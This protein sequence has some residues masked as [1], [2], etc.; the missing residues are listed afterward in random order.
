MA[1]YEIAGIRFQTDLTDPYTKQYIEDYRVAAD[2]AP[3][4]LNITDADVEFER[5]I[6]P[7]APVGMLV[8]IAL[9]RKL[10]KRLL[11]RYQG[12]FLHG[13]ALLYKGKAYMFVAPSGTGKTTHILL[14]KKC[15]GDQVAILNGDKPFMRLENGGITVYSGPWRGKEGFGMKASAP[16]GGVIL[17]HRGAENTIRQAAVPEALQ[18][19][20]VSTVFPEDAEGMTKMLDFMGQI[21]R[22]VPVGILNCNM[23]D[24][25]VYTVKKF[26]EENEKQ[27]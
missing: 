20:L 21:C 3:E 12:I 2:T 7:D 14:W 27:Y 15:L 11:Y 24:D 19:L 25:A 8:S 26:I 9:C 18:R 1:V 13:A 22:T 4:T 23:Q 5:E 6:Q 10:S 17:L 16:L